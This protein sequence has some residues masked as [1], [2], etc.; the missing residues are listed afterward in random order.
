MGRRRTSEVGSTP[1]EVAWAKTGLFRRGS[2]QLV[3]ILECWM[4]TW[5]LLVGSWWIKSTM[6]AVNKKS[7]PSY[8][9]LEYTAR[10]MLISSRHC[11]PNLTSPKNYPSSR[12][13]RQKNHDEPQP[14]AVLRAPGMRRWKPEPGLPRA[15]DVHPAAPAQA[16]ALV[17]LLALHSNGPSATQ[18]SALSSFDQLGGLDGHQH[19]W[20]R[21]QER[22]DGLDLPQQQ[23]YTCFEA[24]TSRKSRLHQLE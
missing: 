24:Y 23:T 11:S 6:T 2:W 10:A 9:L 16:A 8:T 5:W 12:K 13:L 1:L 7:D 17:R 14:S 19:R 20:E 22:A 3:K 18:D 4:T 21:R 15:R